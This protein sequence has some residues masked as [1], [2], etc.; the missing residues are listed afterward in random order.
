ME[1]R[2]RK[3]VASVARLCFVA[4]RVKLDET[5]GEYMLNVNCRVL[6]DER[7]SFTR[8]EFFR[9]EST[10]KFSS[11]G[12][13]KANHLTCGK[14]KFHAVNTNVSAQFIVL[15]QSLHHTRDGALNDSIKVRVKF[16]SSINCLETC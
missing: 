4:T 9:P 5:A 12:T 10:R 3:N 14:R 1:V 2:C 6:H 16:P 11:H 7:S 8:S 13:R 15:A